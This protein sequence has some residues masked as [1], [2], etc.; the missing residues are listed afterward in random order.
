M[1]Y[2][3]FATLSSLLGMM[4]ISPHC[5]Y[6]CNGLSSSGI[7]RPQRYYAIVRL[8]AA[9]RRF[10]LCYR[11]FRL[12]HL[13]GKKL[14]GLPGYRLFSVI[15]MPSSPTPGKRCS[16]CQCAL[17]PV[18]FH[19][20]NRVALPNLESYREVQS[21]Q[22]SLTASCFDYAVLNLWDCSRRPSDLYPV[23]GLP[24]RGG[25]SSH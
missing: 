1:R 4:C 17:Y 25:T 22:L 5:S 2:S 9:Y 23:A 18:G 12:T 19:V 24:C 8:P 10:L 21:V 20:F 13:H 11:L 7:T 16:T 6:Y 3:F 15:N 14:Q